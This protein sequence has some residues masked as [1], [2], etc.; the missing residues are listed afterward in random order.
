MYPT[1][2]FNDNDN[3]LTKFKLHPSRLNPVRRDIDIPNRFII[4]KKSNLPLYHNSTEPINS[5]NEFIQT[6]MLDKTP[7][8]TLYEEDKPLRT[9]AYSASK[10]NLQYC[11]N[12][13]GESGYD[14]LD[15]PIVAN[16]DIPSERFGNTFEGTYN[17]DRIRDYYDIV[18]PHSE[19]VLTAPGQLT[20]IAQTP[21]TNEQM[22]R[23]MYTTRLDA[24]KLE[25]LRK[26][27]NP[28]YHHG[29]LVNPEAPGHGELL[30]E[31]IFEDSKKCT[32][33]SKP[34]N[35]STLQDR[36]ALYDK[37]ILNISK[38]P[39][40]DL[41]NTNTLNF[42]KK[43]LYNIENSVVNSTKLKSNNKV[44]RAVGYLKTGDYNSLSKYILSNLKDLSIE[45]KHIAIFGNSVP[46]QTKQ[47]HQLHTEPQIKLRAVFDILPEDQTKLRFKTLYEN[48]IKD[49]IPSC[50]ASRIILRH[51]PNYYSLDTKKIY[52][53]IENS[54]PD[55]RILTN[56]FGLPQHQKQVFNELSDSVGNT[57]A[58]LQFTK[59]RN[60]RLQ[61]VYDL[62][63]KKQYL[64][65][66]HVTFKPN[67][68]KLKQIFTKTK[69]SI[70][71]L[72]NNNITNLS[73]D[74]SKQ[75]SVGKLH[76]DALG[77]PGFA[78]ELAIDDA[79]RYLKNYDYDNYDDYDSCNDSI[80]NFA[81]SKV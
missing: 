33:F 23:I 67:L 13:I 14:D 26:D 17:P 28:I 4:N 43:S 22:Q 58:S 8:E 41:T 63:N 70:K 7:T 47:L 3:I 48:M 19:A 30:N 31:Q 11:G 12:V 49:G 9:D 56:L 39:M 25:L 62:F 15:N 10:V 71:G 50:I 37:V 51:I 68:L 18:L 35:L 53:L 21:F 64:N 27:L 6:A 20:Q 2:Y 52:D 74:G 73:Y 5:L 60:I 77:M 76:N 24:L 29:L 78:T 80:G 72:M 54:T 44:T 75:M 16:P 65:R 36:G 40:I 38:D 34:L 69:D 81:L 61:A 1:N 59:P 42:I 79:S 32:H 57:A 45:N 46:V 55:Q 66:S